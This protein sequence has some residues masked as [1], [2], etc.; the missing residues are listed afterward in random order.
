MMIETSVGVPMD[1]SALSSYFGRLVNRFFKILPMWE[2]RIANP[3]PKPDVL[4]EESMYDDL[5]IYI[6]SLQIELMGFISLIKPFDDESALISLVSA[7]QYLADNSN[8][9]L[10]IVK[11]EVFRSINTCTNL[12]VKYTS[13]QTISMSEDPTDPEECELGDSDDMGDERSDV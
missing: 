3:V 10:G 6:R 12:K 8:V 11:R 5:E 7:L 13:L 1:V 2:D 9:R 4:D